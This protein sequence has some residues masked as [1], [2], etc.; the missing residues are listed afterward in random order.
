MVSSFVH[1]RFAYDLLL[2]N[3]SILEAFW[4]AARRVKIQRRG[5]PLCNKSLRNVQKSK[6]T[7]AASRSKIN[8]DQRNL[9]AT[10]ACRVTIRGRDEQLC[11]KSLRNSQGSTATN[12]PPR[13]KLYRDERS[14]IVTT[15]RRITIRR[16]GEPLCNKSLVNGN[17]QM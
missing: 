16:R 2:D 10:T 8:R 3:H 15:A 14:L 5:E 7:N 17:E 6:A 13:S 12:A 9:T 11:N 4:V 1:H